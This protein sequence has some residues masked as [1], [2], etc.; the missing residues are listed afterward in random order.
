MQAEVFDPIYELA[1]PVAK[2]I[3]PAAFEELKRNH[4]KTASGL[5]KLGDR[6][7]SV[8]AS[9]TEL[10]KRIPVP[11]MVR[12]QKH[13]KGI[14]IF[15]VAVLT[16]IFTVYPIVEKHL[17]A[18]FHDSVKNDVAEQL[19]EPKA[20][21]KVISASVQKID[22]E[23]DVL[24]PLIQDLLKR[25]IKAGVAHLDKEVE[26]ARKERRPVSPLLVSYLQTALQQTP[27]SSPDY[28][29]AVLQFISVA[30]A[31]LSPE[32]P[33]RNDDHYDFKI[34]GAKDTSIVGESHKVIL[35][36][37]GSLVNSRIYNSRIVFTENPVKMTNV[38]FIN[39]AFE[40]PVTTKPSP[41]LKR[42]T[43]LLLAQ[44]LKSIQIFKFS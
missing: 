29:P 13:W 37:G 10:H 15:A 3:D 31:G 9:I 21:L 25:N 20:D 17:T 38:M 2:P 16:L 40:I 35:L 28:W 11:M 39:C 27:D 34:V 42:A 14:S 41:F 19:V 12:L 24:R 33:A 1:E 43:Q 7:S 36:D 8:N 32:V 44:D 26:M 18:D 6:V 5:E 23:M 30:T 22:G 4:A